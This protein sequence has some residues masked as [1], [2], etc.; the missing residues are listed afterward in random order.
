MKFDAGYSVYNRRMS[1]EYMSNDALAYLMKNDMKTSHGWGNYVKVVAIIGLLCVATFAIATLFSLPSPVMLLLI[2]GIVGVM[3]T[4]HLYGAYPAIFA[5]CLTAMAIKL[6][7]GH[8]TNSDT[9]TMQAFS[10]LF[11]VSFGVITLS[12]RYHRSFVRMMEKMHY[13]QKVEQ[14]YKT[15]MD[16]MDIDTL[17]DDIAASLQMILDTEI[18]I[19]LPD[20]E[21]MH[22]KS[23]SNMHHL[24]VLYCTEECCAVGAG[25]VHFADMDWHYAPLHVNDN[26][27]GVLCVNTESRHITDIY[28]TLISVLA[29]ITSMAIR[30]KHMQEL[31][32]TRTQIALATERFNQF[33]KIEE[34]RT[35]QELEK[36]RSTLLS[37]IAHDLKTP[38]AAIIGSLSAIRHLGSNLK[39]NI[40]HD[41]IATAQTEAERLNH[42]ISNILELTRLESGNF[43]LQMHWEDPEDMIEA[44]LKRL[45]FSQSKHRIHV[46]A[47]N[48]P[49][50]F[51][52]DT[53][54]MEQV[55]HNLLDNCLKYTPEY[56]PVRITYQL[57]SEGGGIISIAD[58]GAGIPEAKRRMIFERFHREDHNKKGTGLGL[59]I[60]KAIVDAH[61]GTITVSQNPVSHHPDFPGSVFTIFLPKACAKQ[62]SSHFFMKVGAHAAGQGRAKTGVLA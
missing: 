10:L 59:A 44:L 57:L 56:S 42:F 21:I 62:D 31:E 11:I 8:D 4:A 6:S 58:Q 34:A 25:T 18:L 14:L 26:Y 60:C 38:L 43:T 1:G 49:C 13:H 39:I 20:H 32:A 17:T 30:R 37:S 28:L 53:T 50:Q 47:I 15:V 55:L 23:A 35:N 16:N 33:R 61:G 27:R 48:P 24:P 29:D 7:V 3:L 41:L 12:N 52:M 9:E 45:S 46:S 51:F 40:Q 19:V 54:L 2:L 22:D 5:L 36:I